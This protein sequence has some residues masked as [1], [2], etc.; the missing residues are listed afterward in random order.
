MSLSPLLNLN[1]N[2]TP[3]DINTKIIEDYLRTLNK[4]KEQSK[5]LDLIPDR[6]TPQMNKSSDD[7]ENHKRS[8]EYEEHCEVIRKRSKE[9][10]NSS[11]QQRLSKA[12]DKRNFYDMQ[13]EVRSFEKLQY[14]NIERTVIRK[15][16]CKY[17]EDPVAAIGYAKRNFNNGNWEFKKVQVFDTHRGHL[18]FD[19]DRP[20]KFEKGV[21]NHL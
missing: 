1:D 11:Y 2:E 3:S 9:F 13:Y 5:S 7:I 8:R 20:G 10:D 18:I 12:Q 17:F 15:H 4:L 14:D 16:I 21:E 6:K 19:S